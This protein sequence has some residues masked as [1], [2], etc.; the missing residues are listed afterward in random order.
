[1]CVTVKR[2]L[3]CRFCVFSFVIAPKYADSLQELILPQS[4]TFKPWSEIAQSSFQSEKNFTTMFSSSVSAVI[5]NELI[6]G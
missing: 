4:N 6:N 1:M 5:N 3:F 2:I